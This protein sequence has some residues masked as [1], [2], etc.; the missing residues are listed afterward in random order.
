MANAIFDHLTSKLPVSRLQRDLTGSLFPWVLVPISWA[1]QNFNSWFNKS[2]NISECLWCCL[3]KKSGKNRFDCVAKYRSSA[4]PHPYCFLLFAKRAW[5]NCAK[6]VLYLPEG[7]ISKFS[8]HITLFFFPLNLEYLPNNREKLHI[9]LEGNWAIVSE[10]IQT[11]LRRE[12][13]SFNPIYSLS[14]S[15]LPHLFFSISFALLPFFLFFFL[16]PP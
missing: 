4:G 2:Q 6:P 8:S 11:I 12:V 16:T 10:A 15:P 14:F 3:W 13:L 7:S 9:D 5:E 1:Y